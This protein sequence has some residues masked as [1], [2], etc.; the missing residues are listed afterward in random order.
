M[1]LR[2]GE[3]HS[4]GRTVTLQLPEA[5]GPHPFKGLKCGPSNGQRLAVSIALIG[6]DET[7][8]PPESQLESIRE[9]RKFE[10]LKR[11]QQAGMLCQDTRFQRFLVETKRGALG[12]PDDFGPHEKQ[13]ATAVRHLC[14]VNSRA[15][16]DTNKDAATKWDALHSE[17]VDWC[18]R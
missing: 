2:W 14:N 9:R 4:S 13:T 10:D 11:S 8:S 3:S 17:Y 18:R 12:P 5:D 15:Q 16:F 6:D 1:L 7:Q